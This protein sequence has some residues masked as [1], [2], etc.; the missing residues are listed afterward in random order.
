MKKGFKAAFR[1]GQEYS[2]QGMMLAFWTSH[3]NN[4]KYCIVHYMYC[5]KDVKNFKT[6]FSHL[7]SSQRKM[8]W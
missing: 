6:F 2:G 7:S 1:C 4:T 3:L 5:D 8:F